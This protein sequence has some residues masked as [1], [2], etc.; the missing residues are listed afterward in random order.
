M[1]LSQPRHGCRAVFRE[2]TAQGCWA[3]P[4]GRRNFCCEC[5]GSRHALRVREASWLGSRRV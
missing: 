1:S 4:A 2:C 3:Q 5:L